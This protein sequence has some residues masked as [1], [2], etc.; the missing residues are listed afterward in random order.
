M[1]QHAWTRWNWLNRTW[2][3]TAAITTCQ[4]LKASTLKQMKES[5]TIH[6][7]YLITSSTRRATTWCSPTTT[8][9]TSSSWG[10]VVTETIQPSPTARLCRHKREA[11]NL[12]QT[13]KRSSYYGGE[14]IELINKLNNNI[15]F[16]NGCH[17]RN[18][19]SSHTIHLKLSTMR[20]N[21][22]TKHLTLINAP[23]IIFI[24]SSGGAPLPQTPGQ[25]KKD[26]PANTPPERERHMTV[27]SREQCDTN[28]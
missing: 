25:M 6:R 15:L 26:R 23:M 1:N 5:R 21:L 2:Y 16:R 24:S 22:T 27:W 13:Q 4:Q 28:T 8:G 17:S 20:T 9:T 14:T 7:A 18:R 10:C 3:H 19:L 11:T 12:M